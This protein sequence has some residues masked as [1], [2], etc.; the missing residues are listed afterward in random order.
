MLAQSPTIKFAWM[1][2]ALGL[3]ARQFE[4][5]RIGIEADH[6]LRRKGIAQQT[7]RSAL[8]TTHVKQHATARGVR[9]S[10]VSGR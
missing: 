7:E 10:A 3:G 4:A 9:P 8:S 6:A 2:F 5:V 1:R